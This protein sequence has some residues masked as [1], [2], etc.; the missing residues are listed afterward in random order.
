MRGQAH[1]RPSNCCRRCGG[2]GSTWH[3]LF[4]CPT[5]DI[6]RRDSCSAR[7]LLCARRVLNVLYTY[8]YI[9]VGKVDRAPMLFPANGCEFAKNHCKTAGK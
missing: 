1:E 2:R 7:L 9:V 3:R 6:T 4:E 5:T 8:I